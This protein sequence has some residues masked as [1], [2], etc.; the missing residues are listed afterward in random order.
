MELNEP[1]CSKNIARKQKSQTLQCM[2]I[3]ACRV[4]QGRHGRVAAGE[5]EEAGSRQACR[6]SRHHLHRCRPQMSF[7]FRL[8]NLEHR[9]MLTAICILPVMA[10]DCYSLTSIAA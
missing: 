9:N 3:Y 2:K 5:R 8:Y 7:C 6:V 1:N 10:D 4:E